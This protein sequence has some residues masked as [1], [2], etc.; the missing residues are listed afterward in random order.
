MSMTSRISVDTILD[1]MEDAITMTNNGNQPPPRW[2]STSSGSDDLV[3]VEK[4]LQALTLKDA[5]NPLEMQL[6]V[7]RGDSQPQ[8][9]PIYWPFLR[10]HPRASIPWAYTQ[11]PSAFGIPIDAKS[12]RQSAGF[13][14]INS[15]HFINQPFAPPGAV[16]IQVCDDRSS[17]VVTT[18]IHSSVL[19][20]LAHMETIQVAAVADGKQ[21][22]ALLGRAQV[23]SAHAPI[24][25][26]LDSSLCVMYFNGPADG[27]NLIVFRLVIDKQGLNIDLFF[28]PSHL[29]EFLGRPAAATHC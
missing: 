8:R 24:P 14:R 10:C 9:G 11:T 1:M 21:S 13:Q 7:V 26:P 28:E 18:S 16:R 17:T 2:Q 29:L 12:A 22:L 23:F 5:P 25:R 4:H 15:A 6:P 19:D 27:R 3:K 20:C